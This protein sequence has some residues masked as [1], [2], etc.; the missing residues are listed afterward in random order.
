MAAPC[1]IDFFL[2]DLASHKIQRVCFYPSA[3][4]FQQTGYFQMHPL[5]AHLHRLKLP[6]SLFF[7]QIKCFIAE[8]GLLFAQFCIFWV[9]F[10]RKLHIFFAFPSSFCLNLQST[11]QSIT[12]KSQNDHENG[13]K[14]I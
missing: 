12:K 7:K 9:N 14:M 5:T 4:S 10:G 1:E 11:S 2:I 8:K 13:L 3:T 6:F